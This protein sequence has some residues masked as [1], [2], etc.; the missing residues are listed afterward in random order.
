MK[1]RLIDKMIQAKND[2]GIAYVNF[3]NNG[4]VKKDERNRT[5]LLKYAN[6]ASAF[7]S[8]EETLYNST[9]SC[10]RE[11]DLDTMEMT[12]L[13][14]LIYN[15]QDVDENDQLL[16][17]AEPM[18]DIVRFYTGEVNS[19]LDNEKT[20][21]YD[22][23]RINGRQGYINYNVLLNQVKKNGLTFNGPESFEEFKEK[24]LAK[25]PFDIN[26]TATLIPTEEKQEEVAEVKELEE[27]PKS[28]IKRI[29]GL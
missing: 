14:G 2:H 27:K 11:Y 28:K 26:L 21:T 25:E 19:Y 7:D 6:E 24:I 3:F 4:E 17:N 13:L 16:E 23:G 22:Y 15:G 12:L 8:I 18:K 29:F 10:C 1:E 9:E 20:N 5:T